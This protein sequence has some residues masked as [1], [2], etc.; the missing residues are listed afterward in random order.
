M[1]PMST[2]E[3]PALRDHLT[4]PDVRPAVIDDAVALLDREVAA[5]SGV[6]GLAVKSAYKVL[7]SAK[8]GMVR[9]SVDSLLDPFADALDPFWATGQATGTPLAQLLPEQQDSMAEALLAITDRRAQASSHKAV[10][11][12]YNKV[13]G[14]AHKQVATAAQGV[15]ELVDKYAP[16]AA[17]G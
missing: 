13:R 2:P 9:S 3:T 7:H 14:M 11:A 1:K 16:V 4:A 5:R 10:R 8:P 12:A 15:G 6:S 17:G